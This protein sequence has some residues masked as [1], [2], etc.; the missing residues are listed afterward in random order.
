MYLS[1]FCPNIY[2]FISLLK[3]E[4]WE[5]YI[6]LKKINSQLNLQNFFVYLTNYLVW[7]CTPHEY[8]FLQ[9]NKRNRKGKSDYVTMRRNRKLNKLFN[10]KLSNRILCDKYQFNRHF[11]SF[12]N[13][14]FLLI[15]KA[16]THEQL[17]TFYSSLKDGKF[18]IKPND[19]YYGIGISLGTTLEQL[20]KLKEIHE[21]TI[22]E[23]IVYNCPEL[24][25]INNSSLNTIR[26]V[27]CID[28]CKNCHIIGAFLRTGR[29]GAIIDNLLG[30][31]TCYPINLETGIID[32]KGR[33][34]KGNY[35]IEHPTSHITMIG[36][37]IPSFQEVIEYAKQLALHLP[38]ARYVGWD[39][40]ITTDRLEVIEGNICP[41]AELIQCNGV[42]LYKYIRS[43]L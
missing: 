30:G 37:K 36:Y 43:L 39:I 41:S 32:G 2:S 1:R 22:V 3:I 40:A 15:N 31:G 24:N 23:E 11:H 17:N 10:S 14:K 18:L 12:I 13:R 6:D 21:S 8:D 35:Y 20:T 27:T 9:F 42:G 34:A 26:V 33:D 5:Q 28:S 16:T 29:K 7:G 38:N 4:L 25:I 19:L